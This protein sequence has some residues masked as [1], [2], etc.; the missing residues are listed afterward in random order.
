ME[1][2]NV[3]QATAL[4]AVAVM[5][6][7]GAQASTVTYT[8]NAAGTTF[9]T[10]G[11]ITNG[12]LT[13]ADGLGASATLTFVPNIGS[14]TGVPS[15]INYGDFLLTCAACSTQ[16]I[17]AGAFFNPFTFDLVIVDSTDGASGTFLGKST[18]GTVYSNVSQVS[19]VWTPTAIGPGTTNVTTGN[20]GP[21]SFN[22][23]TNT[24]IVAPNSGT[25]PGDTTV[26]GTVNSNAVPEPATFGVLGAALLGLGLI[27]RGKFARK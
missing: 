19:I 21:T 25:P 1:I 3:L 6:M 24:G 9:L 18:G 12:G 13:L 23:N 20:F 4:T 8:T 11:T 27:G 2:R 17:G 5:M 26:Q 10:G 7:A 22:I 16:A 14:I 15:N